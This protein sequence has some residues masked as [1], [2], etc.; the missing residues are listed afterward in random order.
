ML[1]RMGQVLTVLG[2]SASKPMEVGTTIC[3]IKTFQLILIRTKLYFPD[4]TD[5]AAVG[6]TL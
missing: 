5:A 2:V 4:D 3:F 1:S 6:T